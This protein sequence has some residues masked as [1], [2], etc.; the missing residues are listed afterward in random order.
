MKNLI[1]K[2]AKK[3]FLA[4]K[5]P[6]KSVSKVYL[7]SI[8]KIENEHSRYMGVKDVEQIPKTLVAHLEK[9]D[10]ITH[11]LDAHSLGGRAIDLNIINPI[12]GNY[13]TGSSSGTAVN[14]FLGIN[15]LG[16]GTDGGGSVLAPAISLNLFSFISP[17]ISEEEMKRHQKT[18]TDNI[19]FSPSVGFI[20][21]DFEELSKAIRLTVNIESEKTREVNYLS[22]ENSDLV[23]IYDT[24][25]TLI[26]FLNETLPKYD[27][28]ISYEGP[29]DVNGFGDSVFGQ[30]D[31]DTSRVQKNA[32]KGL[33]RV[34]NM[35]NA[36]A[37]TIPDSKLGCAY[38]FVCQ[39]TEDKIYNMIQYAKTYVK[40]TNSLSERYFL[41]H[42]NYFEKGF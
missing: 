15:D 38:V 28:I 10:Y 5:N 40:P 24:R 29:V 25:N 3:S 23:D 22:L 31:E 7:N 41:N 12:T 42:N 20:A 39:S 4:Q 27:F 35:V 18:S 14:V 1:I 8:D 26:D 19:V 13:M 32:K 33:I 17:K 6:Y 36:T 2:Y 37:I 21:R 11:T 30:Y 16:V 34:C 9:N